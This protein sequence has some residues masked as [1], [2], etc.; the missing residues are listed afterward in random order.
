MSKETSKEMSEEMS[1]E[2]Y[3]EREYSDLKD[4]LSGFPE[5]KIKAYWDNRMDFIKSAYKRK[6]QIAYGLSLAFRG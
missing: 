1:F 2:E 3:C 5:E 4:L 6:S